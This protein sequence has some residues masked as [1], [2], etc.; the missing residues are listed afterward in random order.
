[1]LRTR[2]KTI[3]DHG[4]VARGCVPETTMTSRPLVAS[5]LLPAPQRSTMTTQVTLSTCRHGERAVLVPSQEF[6][7]SREPTTPDLFTNF[8]GTP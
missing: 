2:A 4:E 8:K 6:D 1:M 7:A 3:P 5:D